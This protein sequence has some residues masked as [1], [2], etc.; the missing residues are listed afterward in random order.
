VGCGAIQPP[1]K[2]S[3]PF[4]ILGLQRRFEL[5]TQEIDIAWRELSRKVHPDRFAGSAAVER[6]MSLQWTA[7]INDARK[8]LRDRRS[9]AHYL[10][11]GRATP[12]E[13]RK[14]QLDPTFLEE[15]FELQMDAKMDP[16]TTRPRVE[17]LSQEVWSALEDRFA[18]WEAGD[19][20]L[21]GVEDLLAKLR[22][23]D[24]ALAMTEPS[25]N[26]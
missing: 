12:S 23:I 21:S 11:T 24:N 19:S 2:D 3:D 26:G 17:A 25:P 14:L 4:E 18:R 8:V 7:N 20:D 1:R 16:V 6:R 5:G 15:M 9:R 13:D 10:A 22:Y